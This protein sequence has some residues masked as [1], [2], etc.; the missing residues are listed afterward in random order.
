MSHKDLNPTAV[1]IVFTDLDGTLL[2]TERKVS[3]N[4][5]TILNQLGEN[6]IVRVIATGR[7]LYSFMQVIDES[8]PADY[9]IFSS[10]A[11]II[12]LQN[13]ELLFSANLTD[14]E[15]LDISG[16]LQEHQADFMVHHQV[17]DNHHFVYLAAGGGN[18]DFH[19][20][21]NIYRAFAREYGNGNQFPAPAAQIIAVLER[22]LPRFADLASGLGK[23]QVTRTTSPLDHHSIWMEIHPHNV[24]KGSAAA[25]LCN[26]LGLDPA[27]SVGIG[28]DYNDIDL[29]D[30]TAHSYLLQ[31]SPT[32]LHNRYHLARSNDQDGFYH[33][34]ITVFS[35]S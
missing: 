14:Q 13:G 26:H 28:N 11:G 7:S 12:D 19:R 31:N 15:V 27:S 8:F 10:G 2:N 3:A 16:Q 35:Q 9:L 33:A 24:N 6:G 32:E 29:L 22:D 20:R 17:P 25:W 5:L 18:L 4:N 21:I 1:G 23:Y 34:V 30:F